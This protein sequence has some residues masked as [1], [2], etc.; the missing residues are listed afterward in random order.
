MPQYLKKAIPVDA[1]KWI[2][3]DSK[4][5]WVEDALNTGRIVPTRNAGVYR[6]KTSEGTLDLHEGN[7]VLRSSFDDRIW[8]VDDSYFTANYDEA[9]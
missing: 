8:P 3:G 5:A 9:P 7:W 4:P 2:E 1:Y 6:I